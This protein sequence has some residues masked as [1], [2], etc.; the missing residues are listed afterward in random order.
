MRLL[1]NS[2]KIG[3][4]LYSI[5]PESAFKTILKATDLSENGDACT[6]QFD[7]VNA[8]GECN[9]FLPKNSTVTSDFRDLLFDLRKSYIE[10]NQPS[11]N[12]CIFSIDNKTGKFEVDF[13]YQDEAT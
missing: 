9:W 6:F 8:A 12:G 11:W 10:N 2:E 4:I 1:H 5:S 3:Y 7:Y 13:K